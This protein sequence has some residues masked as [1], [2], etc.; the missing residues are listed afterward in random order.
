MPKVAMPKQAM[1]GK[2]VASV[3]QAPVLAA[4]TGM[5]PAMAAAQNLL[6]SGVTM[7][8]ATSSTPTMHSNASLHQVQQ[9]QQRYNQQQL[10][11]FASAT[12]AANAAQAN[13][14]LPQQ[15]Q[16]QPQLQAQQQ[17]QQQ[18]QQVPS[19]VVSN[20]SAPAVASQPTI[21]AGAAVPTA[22]AAGT[23]T[24]PS[25]PAAPQVSARP[26]DIL[27]AIVQEAK[28]GVPDQLTKAVTESKTTLGR[29][30]IGH[31]EGVSLETLK[32]LGLCHFTSIF[33]DFAILFVNWV[34]L[35]E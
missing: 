34:P 8:N 17:Q 27:K 7:P 26:V 23:T 20:A 13:N 12:A 2:Q 16:P 5:N 14:L 1:H 4:P 19:Q 22:A 11:K 3:P 6:N 10:A 29:G 33:L 31:R 35:N 9:L 21:V 15:P 25:V 28:D 30:L 32:S 18:Q 24:V